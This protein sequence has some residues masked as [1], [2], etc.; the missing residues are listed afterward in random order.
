MKKVLL[1]ASLYVSFSMALFA[2]GPHHTGMLID[3]AAYD[4]IPVKAR[5]VGFQD[6]I[7]EVSNASI[8]KYVPEIKNQGNYG[9]CVGWSSAYYGR[10]I[11]QA[12][13]NNITS[14]AEINKITFSPAF[15]YLNSNVENDYN[16]QGG[17]YVN[18]ALQSMVDYGAPY[19]SE[20]NLNC[21]TSIPNYVWD[22]ASKN[23]IKD[24][25]R[26]FSG[27]E[28]KNLKLESVKRSLNNGNPVIIGF[29]VENSFY[30]AKNVYEPDYLGTHGGHAMAVVGFDDDKYGGAFEI[31]NSWGKDWGNAG[32]I[33][34]RYD[35]FIN[36]T[37]YAYEMIPASTAKEKTLAGKL[38]LELMGGGKMD[39]SKGDGNYRKTILG[40]QDVVVE[41]SAQSIGDYET[42]QSYPNDTRYRMHVEVE[43]PCYVYVFAADTDQKN[44]VLFPHK[45]EISAYISYDNTEVI[46]PGERLWFRMSGNVESDYSIVI[47]TEERIDTEAVKNQLDS[48]NGELMDKLYVIFKD[49]LV[50]KENVN[51]SKNEIAFNAKFSSGS[52]VMLLLDIKRS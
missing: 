40:W 31:V 34:V 13:I 35:D 9:T 41:Q 26:L 18:V 20:Y 50:S 8:K 44:N 38:R 25:N 2:Q 4:K 36:Y 28:D 29:M 12:R 17:A 22:A 32:Y 23:K 21:D 11:L 19:F 39:V 47:F 5:N 37:R 14:Q 24:Y 33:W 42:S 52:M 7:A 27:S 1:F 3:D 10:T 15:T 48:M 45:P 30:Y 46:V 6:V 43:K 49:K 16:C 51:L